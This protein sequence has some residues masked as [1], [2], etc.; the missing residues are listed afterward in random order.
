MEE[1]KQTKQAKNKQNR[2][3][4]HTCKPV[5]K[6]AVE[7]EAELTKTTEFAYQRCRQRHRLLVPNVCAK[8]QV[9]LFQCA[10]HIRGHIQC[11]FDP[12]STPIRSASDQ[13]IR[14]AGLRHLN[15]PIQQVC[16]AQQFLL[17]TCD[18]L[19]PLKLQRARETGD[20]R[21][22]SEASDFHNEKCS[23]L[24]RECVY[25]ICRCVPL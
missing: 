9:N 11:R 14:S 6:R 12:R 17:F 13:I 2:A 7:C 24:S 25:S 3:F 8:V 1:N 10:P 18:P 16:N 19:N 4:D 22:A 15:I 20:G 23:S 5:A 21:L